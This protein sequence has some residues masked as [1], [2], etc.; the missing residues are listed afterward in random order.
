MTKPASAAKE[1]RPPRTRACG[2][3]RGLGR[4]FLGSGFWGRGLLLL[5][6]PP[7]HARLSASPHLL[8][9]Q[10]RGWSCAPGTAL[11]S[12]PAASCF[13]TPRA[14]HGALP[15]FQNGKL[16]PG[17]LCQMHKSKDPN[18][19]AGTHRCSEIPAHPEQPQARSTGRRRSRNPIFSVMDGQTG[20]RPFPCPSSP[21]ARV[22]WGLWME[23]APCTPPLPGRGREVSGGPAILS[24]F[25]HGVLWARQG[26][27]CWLL[28]AAPYQLSWPAVEG[29][30]EGGHKLGPSQLQARQNCPGLSALLWV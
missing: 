20:A 1:S 8:D 17:A 16:R 23:S 14:W 12:A 28:Q 26:Q 9:Q 15:S 13:R 2:E 4:A 7:L 22:R 27:D 6:L 25:P 30:L 11:L 21:L 18:R 5:P 10:G 3:E 29:G 19:D 24:A